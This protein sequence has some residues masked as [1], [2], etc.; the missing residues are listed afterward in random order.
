MSITTYK[1]GIDT[2]VIAKDGIVASIPV[3]I[4]GNAFKDLADLLDGIIGGALPADK[5]TMLKVATKIDDLYLLLG[6]YTVTS[7]MNTLLAGKVNVDGVKVLSDINFSTTKDAKLTGI[8]TAATANDTDANLKNRLNH[9]GTQSS[10]TLTDGTTSKSFLATERTKLAG[11]AT[12]ATANSADATLLSRTNHTGTQSAD[13]V[14]DTSSTNKFWTNART[15]SSALT[16]YVKA[17]SVSA[18]SAT[19]T[20]LTAIG[21]LEKALDAKQGTLTSGTNLKTIAGLSLLSSGDIDVPVKVAGKILEN[22][23]P[24]YN[25]TSTFDSNQFEE[26]DS[27]G[28]V[29]KLRVKQNVSTVYDASLLY[30]FNEFTAWV[31]NGFAT[32]DISKI[33]IL[34][35][36]ST[37]TFASRQQTF[38]NY[39]TSLRRS[40]ITSGAVTAAGYR[41][42]YRAGVLPFSLRR[43]LKFRQIFCI[44]DP[45]AVA[46]ARTFVGLIN[47]SGSPN[48]AEVSSNVN[49]IGIGNDTADTNMS[50]I[51]N[52]GTGVAT[53]IDLGVNF[54]ANTINSD[55]YEL[56]LNS[57]ANSGIVTYTV[58]NKDATTGTIKG[59]A[60]GTIST[61]LPALTAGLAPHFWRNNNST[62]L[63]IA[64]DCMIMTNESGVY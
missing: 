46:G 44:S 2:N 27:G 55:V 23:L 15:I 39:L 48:S 42:S 50:I 56:N 8:A 35:P 47:S 20:V 13:T 12:S 59:T 9:T 3:P 63:E 49:L 43:G 18:I 6:N 61:D 10:D 7:D 60:I 57:V 26:Y 21:I 37:G 38:A 19:T 17:A 36:S 22:D 51:S 53:K 24:V 34:G 40:A 25:I 32:A 31:F 11:I 16:G 14:V 4:I 62:A 52:D 41:L 28:S 64:M 45:A 30:A 54:P 33:G 29:L 58:I 1:S 5:D